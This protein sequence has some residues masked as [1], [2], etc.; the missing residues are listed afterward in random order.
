MALPTERVKS[1]VGFWSEICVWCPVP[2]GEGT[3][4]GGE[5]TEV[6]ETAINVSLRKTIL[7]TYLY[8]LVNPAQQLCTNPESLSYK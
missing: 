4:A 2:F 1:K 6:E 3:R 8:C 7:L 5:M